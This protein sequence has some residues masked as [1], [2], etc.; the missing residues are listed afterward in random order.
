[1]FRQFKKSISL[2]LVNLLA[3]SVVFAC[4]LLSGDYIQKERSYDRHHL[5]ADRI[6]NLFDG[7]IVTEV[8][9]KM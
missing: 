5:N 3:L 2:R 1:M 8:G 4:L 7:E 9:S 6:I